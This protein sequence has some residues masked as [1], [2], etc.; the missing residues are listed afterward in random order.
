MLTKPTDRLHLSRIEDLRDINEATGVPVILIGEDGL[1]GRLNSKRRIYSRVAEVVNFEP[2][3]AQDVI[4]YGAKMAEL[5]ISPEAAA[6]LVKKSGGSFRMIHNHM[7]KISEYAQANKLTLVETSHV[8]SLQL[9]E[10]R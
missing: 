9:R 8:D 5:K 4:L 3:Q 7:L 10:G 6:K 2:V 1:M